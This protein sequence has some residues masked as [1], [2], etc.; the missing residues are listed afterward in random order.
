MWAMAMCMC[1]DMA[2]EMCMSRGV[3]KGKAISGIRAQSRV[4][5]M[6]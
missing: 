4:R 3:C 6:V 5:V 2:M 1:M